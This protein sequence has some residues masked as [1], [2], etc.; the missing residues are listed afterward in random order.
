VLDDLAGGWEKYNLDMGKILDTSTSAFETAIPKI[1]EG[2][3]IDMSSTWGADSGVDIE[4]FGDGSYKATTIVGGEDQGFLTFDDPS[5]ITAESMWNLI[6][7]TQE[8][9]NRIVSG[10]Y[11]DL[12]GYASGGSFIA[13]ERGPELVTIQGGQSANISSH[14][15]TM[16]MLT[17]AVS[18]GLKGSGGEQHIHVNVGNK[19]IAHLVIDTLTHNKEAKYQVK[20]AANG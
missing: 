18:D 7:N 11:Y 17:K 1:G 6:E 10:D 20:R 12:P 2:F 16:S 9:L 19:E 15:D 8:W 5:S 13:G 14:Q 3:E 4:K